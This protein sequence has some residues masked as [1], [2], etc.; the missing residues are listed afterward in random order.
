MPMAL[1]MMLNAVNAAVAT[2]PQTIA[3]SQLMATNPC[4]AIT[5]KINTTGSPMLTRR[6]VRAHAVVC[7]VR[8]HSVPEVT[9][10]AV[11]VSSHEDRFFAFAYPDGRR[12]TPT[13]G[14]AA[15]PE[16]AR[17]RCPN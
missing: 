1:P 4:T 3:P 2:T 15:K 9:V 13:I 12:P 10:I 16:T 5:A 7:P 8:V 17:P 6:P 11:S 14:R